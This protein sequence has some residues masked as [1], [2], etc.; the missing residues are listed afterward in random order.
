MVTQNHLAEERTELA[1]ERTILAWQRNRLSELAVLLGMFGLGIAIP[2]LYPEYLP[3]GLVIIV[4][5]CAG[6]AYT[7]YRYWSLKK[8]W[9]E[10]EAA[11]ET[12]S[13]SYADD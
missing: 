8:A 1:R 6:M 10:K 2:S 3:A 13:K 5:A 7:L 9:R 12:R 4:I 11:L